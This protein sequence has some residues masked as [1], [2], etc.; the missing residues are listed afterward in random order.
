MHSRR[1]A[2]KAQGKVQ[3][4]CRGKLHIQCRP[5]RHGPAH[6]AACTWASPPARKQAPSQGLSVPTEASVFKGLLLLPGGFI[7]GS[8]KWSPVQAGRAQ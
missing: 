7:Q 3:G 4:R 6:L 8:K 2:M 5:L 1:P